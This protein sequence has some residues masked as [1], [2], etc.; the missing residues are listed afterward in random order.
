MRL[1][2]GYQTMIVGTRLG[3]AIRFSENDARVIGRTARGVRAITLSKGDE[4]IGMSICRE[5]GVLLTVTETGFGRLSELEDY[6]IQTRGGKGLINYHTKQ[7]G[8]VAAIKVVDI[9]DD[10]I[11]IASDGIIIRMA[12]N[13]IRLCRRPSKGVRVMRL[14]DGA[15]IVSLARAPQEEIGDDI[16]HTGQGTESDGDNIPQDTVPEDE[17]DSLT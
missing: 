4:V 16:D 11:L 14:D 7:F 5:N 9:S 8:N 10:I 15:R 2:D 12:A 3:K 1:T 13:E 6:R 17:N